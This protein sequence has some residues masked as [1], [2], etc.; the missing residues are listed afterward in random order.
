MTFNRFKFWDTIQFQSIKSLRVITQALSS[1][2][3]LTLLITIEPSWADSR[4]HVHIQQLQQ[5]TPEQRQ[6]AV[7]SLVNIGKPAVTS[8]IKALKHQQ[9]Q[10]RAHAANALSQMGDNAAPALPVLSQALRDEDKRVRTEAALAFNNIGKRAMVPYLVANLHNENPSVR[11]SAVHALT[12]LGK[13]AQ[14]AVPKLVQ[15]LESDQET[16]VRLTAASALGSIGVNAVESLPNLVR[17]LEDRDI[18]VRHSA[19]YALGAIAVSFQEQGTQVSSADLDKVI[20]H[21]SKALTIMK[22]PDWKF[23]EQAVTSIDVP[24]AALKKVQVKPIR[25][26]LR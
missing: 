4:V 7:K 14:S 20:T 9:P 25:N 24:L 6:E 1:S 19:A 13:Y 18:S 17:G 16:W 3:F 2:L 5:G 10:V 26:T 23:R 15:T 11:Y 12:R 22:K 8:L 21:L